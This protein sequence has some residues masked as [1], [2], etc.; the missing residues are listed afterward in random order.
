M[1]EFCLPNFRIAV[2]SQAEL[3]S[4][5]GCVMLGLELE[6]DTAA[7]EIFTNQGILTRLSGC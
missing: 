3:V 4:G 5:G 2:L 7:R 1:M 6:R